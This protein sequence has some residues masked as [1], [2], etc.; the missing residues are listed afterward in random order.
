MTTELFGPRVVVGATPRRSALA[1][2]DHDLAA[3]VADLLAALVETLGLDRHDAAIG[4]GCGH[5]LFEHTGLGVNG[6]A[7]KGRAPVGQ[8]LDF[9]VGDRRTRH[10]RDRKSTRLNSS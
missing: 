2:P 4:L 8:R 1:L 10:V 7:V 5:A 3:E 9:E 6:V